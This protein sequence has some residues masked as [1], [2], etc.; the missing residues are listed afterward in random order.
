MTHPSLDRPFLFVGRDRELAKI[1]E[2]FDA[3]DEEAPRPLALTGI[4]GIGKT[5]LARRYALDSREQRGGIWIADA[6]N[7]AL[8]EKGVCAAAE[9]AA[10]G[11]SPP[12]GEQDSRAAAQEAMELL[13]A[14][15]QSGRRWLL[16][17]DGAPAP[18]ALDW[19]RMPVGLDL[20][21]TSPWSDWSSFADSFALN[22]PPREEAAEMVMLRSGQADVAAASLLA[23]A[24]GDLPLALDHAAV[25]ARRTGLGLDHVASRIEKVISTVPRGGTQSVSVLAMLELGLDRAIDASQLAGPLIERLSWYAAEVDDLDLLA[26][27][28]GS[29]EKRLDAIAALTEL[30][31]LVPVAGKPGQLTSHDLVRQA[32]RMRAGLEG[33]RAALARLAV[34]MP[35]QTGDPAKVTILESLA[36]HVSAALGYE[37]TA[38]ARASRDERQLA[39]VFGAHAL[40]MGQAAVAADLVSR[41]LEFETAVFPRS[42]ARVVSALNNLAEARWTLGDRDEA[43]AL[44]RRGLALQMT[45]SGG[46]HPRVGVILQNLGEL[47]RQQGRLEDAMV[48]LSRA[49]AIEEQA[50]VPDGERTSRRMS[51]LALIHAAQGDGAEAERLARAAVAQVEPAVSPRAHAFRLTNLARILRENGRW[52]EAVATAEEAVSLGRSTFSEGH[53]ELARLLNEQGLAQFAAGNTE[54]AVVILRSALTIDEARFTPSH[55]HVLTTRFNLASALARSRRVVEAR[56]QLEGIF[57]FLDPAETPDLA[58][59]VKRLLT[60]LNAD[61]S[62]VPFTDNGDDR[63]SRT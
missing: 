35:E 11:W 48:F 37:C 20:L 52:E 26:G 32:A 14:L 62:L 39:F 42:P 21:I 6:S 16:I 24:V 54:V 61:S 3:T 46:H 44:Y 31:L 36:P 43:E 56:A 41:S 4:D 13:G 25:F 63:D 15:A 59:V 10:K 53:P 30:S 12:T 5:A 29:E 47:L 38:P 33:K 45:M 50:E 27:D 2:Y 28:L 23:A 1:A 22:S 49:L 60:T 34:G 58:V 17:L 55:Y 18:N 8:L 9:A 57:R 40:A 51:A 7:P 19:L